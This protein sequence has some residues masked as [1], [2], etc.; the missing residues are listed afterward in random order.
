MKMHSFINGNFLWL[1][2]GQNIMNLKNRSCSLMDIQFLHQFLNTKQHYENATPTL[3]EEV[4]SMS[5]HS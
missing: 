4:H 2:K 5:S 1:L 3:K